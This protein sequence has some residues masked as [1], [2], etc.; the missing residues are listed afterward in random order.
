[1]LT[2]IGVFA[3]AVGTGFLS[4]VFPPVNAEAAIAVGANVASLTRGICWVAGIA[5]GQTIGKIVIYEA[6]RAGK[7]LHSRRRSSAQ[8]NHEAAG[9]TAASQATAQGPAGPKP[10]PESPDQTTPAG[11]PDRP[12]SPEPSHHQ[13]AA[14][15]TDPPLS[16]WQ[17]IR[18]WWRRAGQRLLAL[19]DDRWR[20]DA[21]LLLSA[22][23]GLPPLLAT[24]A[25]AGALKL[26]RLDFVVCVLAGRLARFFV[27]AAPFFSLRG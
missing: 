15:M 13:P 2:L 18:A 27:I 25:L 7:D 8:T 26:R 11:S 21:V 1:M 16:R 9:P 22:T 3:S 17:R 12:P 14:P 10:L 4:A 6:A 5:C 24:A 23:V 19:M 20:G